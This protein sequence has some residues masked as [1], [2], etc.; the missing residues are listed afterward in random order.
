M[1]APVE[2]THWKRTHANHWLAEVAATPGGGYKYSAHD[3]SARSSG[4]SG[5]A[6]DL[7]RAQ[8]LADAKVPAHECACEAWLI[9]R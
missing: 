5:R 1:D 6:A 3:L 4:Q 8:E 9:V 2:P 7:S